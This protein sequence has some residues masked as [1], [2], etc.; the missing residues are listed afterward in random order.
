VLRYHGRL[1]GPLLDRI[2]LQIEVPTMAPAMLGAKA[3]AGESTAAIAARVA[4]A[5]A[6]QL[7]RQGKANHRL[8]NQEIALHCQLDA[9]GEQL[10][11]G[12]MLRLHWSARTY[13]RV[14]RVARS[15]ADLA[16]GAP[17]A[18]A[19][20]AEAIQYRRVLHVV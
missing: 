20:V 6:L 3:L 5:F 13:H 9:S 14:L 1:S 7:A 12:A 19:H 4:A 8:E 10:L 15:I 16:G 2:D 18:R 11:H 17:I